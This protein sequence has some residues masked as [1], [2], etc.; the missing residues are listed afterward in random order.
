MAAA[1]FPNLPTLAQRLREELETKKFMLVYAYNATGKTRLSS[2]FKDLGKKVNDDGE[3]TQRDTLYFNAFTE[4]LFN[5]DNDLTGDRHR[6]LKLNEKSRYFSGLASTE[7]D[8]RIRS[9]LDRYAD[10]DFRIDSETDKDLKLTKAEVVFF[11]KEDGGTTGDDEEN[12]FG[13]KISRGEE[14]VFIWCFFLAILQLTLD[15][16]EDYKWVKYVY[17]DDPV[18]SL[19]EHNAIVFGNHLVQLYR[20]AKRHVPTVVSTH[21]ALF[22]NVLHYEIKNHLGRQPQYM[23]KR[24]KSTGGYRLEEQKRDTP[25]FYH[26]SALEELWKLAKEEKIS[27]YHFNVLRSILEKTAFFLGYGHFASCIKRDANDPDGVLH[28]RFVDILSH[29]KYSMYEPVEMQEQTRDYFRA[30]LS[31]FVERHPFN[32]A[33]LPNEKE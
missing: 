31:G 23:L 29:G 26:I 24:D 17:I 19:D 30:I 25:Q 15:G 33:L 5:W 16:S 8:T 18:S 4:D 14:S 9:L 27:T 20:E 3:T 13:I 1:S 28:Q 6:F 10:F 12:T 22:F 32:P 11:R 2:A 21:H 7:L